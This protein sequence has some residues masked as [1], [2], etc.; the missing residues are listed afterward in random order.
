[1]LVIK[2]VRVNVLGIKWE[3]VRSFVSW[4]LLYLCN[5]LRV[6]FSKE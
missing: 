1:M 6:Y 3:D 2:C 4:G 5:L